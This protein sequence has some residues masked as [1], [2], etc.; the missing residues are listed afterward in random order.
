MQNGLPFIFDSHIG[1]SWGTDYKGFRVV[2]ILK[3]NK[4]LTYMMNPSVKLKEDVFW[5]WIDKNFT[6]LA[7]FFLFILQNFVKLV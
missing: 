3:D 1:G 4:L 6:S 2:E 5:K 7:K